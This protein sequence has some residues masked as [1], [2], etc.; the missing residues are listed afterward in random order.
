MQSEVSAIISGNKQVA[1]KSIRHKPLQ[2]VNSDVSPFQVGKSQ[3]CPKN[4]QTTLFT[5]AC[6]YIIE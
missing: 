1:A 6:K 2:P 4:I 3:L 5:Q